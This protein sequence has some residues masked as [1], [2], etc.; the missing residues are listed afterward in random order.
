MALNFF[1]E[2]SPSE[3]IKGPFRSY[4]SIPGGFTIFS[5]ITG[6][7]IQALGRNPLARRTIELN[8]AIEFILNI[9][10]I[11]FGLVIA[12]LILVL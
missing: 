5:K 11:V 3:E 6:S 10:L 9:A 12:Y 4:I 7:G 2:V 1:C 8:L